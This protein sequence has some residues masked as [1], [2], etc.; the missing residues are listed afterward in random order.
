[1]PTT[2]TGT[3]VRFI[4]S[5]GAERLG[6]FVLSA[7][8]TGIQVDSGRSALGPASPPAP[9]PELPARRR[10][11]RPRRLVPDVPAF[12][13]GGS[14]EWE[15]TSAAGL[16]TAADVLPFE[17]LRLKA[18]LLLDRA[19]CEFFAKAQ[20]VDPAKPIAWDDINQP[21]LRIAA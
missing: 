8:T 13:I 5:A 21:R 14:I 3:G 20:S 2:L 16:L 12:G 1:L 7:A 4:T 18:E 10:P 6:L 19:V 11:R 9:P 17:D 15:V